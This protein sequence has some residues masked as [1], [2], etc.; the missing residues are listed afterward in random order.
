M[1]PRRTHREVIEDIC[2]DGID[3]SPCVGRYCILKELVLLDD[4]G[5][6]FLEQM[7]CIERFKYERSK[8]EDREIGWGEAHKLWIGEGFADRFAEVYQDGMTKGQLY[9]LTMVAQAA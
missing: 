1:T 8:K 6:R 4:K 7:K 5:D 3:N 2:G 9:D